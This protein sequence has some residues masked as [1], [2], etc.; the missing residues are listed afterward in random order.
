MR[1]L[2]SKNALYAIEVLEKAGFSAYLV[3]GCVRDILMGKTP[4]DF[5][6]TTNALPHITESLFPNEKKVLSGISHG[7]VAPIIDGEMVEITTFRIDGEYTD[8]RH[9][10]KVSFTGNICD[11]LK[12]R[13]FTVNAIAM[14]KNL[15]LVDPFSGKRDIEKGI[16][17]C[18]GNP[19]ERFSEDALRI[20][21]A[22]RFSSTLGFLIEDETKKAVFDKKEL[23]LNISK[24]RIFSELKKLIEGK[25][26]EKV[27]TSYKEV[28][29]VIVPQLKKASCRW[30][31]MSSSDLFVNFAL[32]FDGLKKEEVIEAIMSL[33]G[34]KKTALYTAKLIDLSERP[35]ESE[36]DIKNLLRDNDGETLR[37][38]TEIKFLK[39]DI[40]KEEQKRIEELIF[41]SEKSCTKIS[42]LEIKGDDLMK[43]GFSGRKIGDCLEALLDLVISERCKNDRASL[44]ECAK[45][46]CK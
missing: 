34:D 43:L 42:D 13:D 7:T 2:I 41:V 4:Y 33:K 23:L 44:I 31:N 28:L 46:L 16:L 39:G 14:D 27:L 32:F 37:N 3:G 35:L 40:T 12:R 8:S 24:E 15:R 26:K 19:Y 17:R 1:K 36:K 11:D 29:Y 10:E 25:D 5:D 9:P 6:I 30:E 22:L 20:M 38:L 18:V 45:R 21:R